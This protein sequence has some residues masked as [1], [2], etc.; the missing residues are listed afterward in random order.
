LKIVDDQSMA[1]PAKK[2]IAADASPLI[3]L[4][5]ADAF[6]LLQQLFGTI[7]ITQ[8]VKDEV[9]AG[10]MLPGA[11]ELH[12]AMR[13]GW[14]RVAPAPLETWRIDGLDS[15]EASTIALALQH[16]GPRLVLM[17]DV[18]GRAQAAANGLEVIGLAGLLF[19]AQRARLIGEVQPLLARL[20]RRGFI[21]SDDSIREASEAPQTTA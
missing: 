20:A 5:T 4:A 19:A 21:V 12:S 1:K 7:T 18:L 8:L 13:E 15:G 2:L 6:D 14:I 3:G 17:D 16:L 10:G 11:R 9:L